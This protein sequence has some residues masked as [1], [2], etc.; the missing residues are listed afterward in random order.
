[1]ARPALAL[2]VAASLV[3][4]LDLAHK[5]GAVA[6]S[7][8]GVPAHPRS[9][10]YVLGIALA[11]I[12][13]AGALVLTRSLSIALGGG[14]LVGG[15]A[16]NV[17]SLALWPAVDGVPNPLSAGTVA[18]NLADAASAV[19]FAS[20]LATTV[21]YATGNRERWQDPVRLRA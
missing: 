10:L 20:V 11:S 9:A 7:G 12:L 14:V 19:G 5:A 21:V 15:A 3:A 4:A 16:A 8:S 1:M 13:W 6:A 17:V 2:T 18:F